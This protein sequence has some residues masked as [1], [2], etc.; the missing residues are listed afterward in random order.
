MKTT[1]LNSKY[2]E[3]KFHIQTTDGNIVYAN[4]LPLYFTTVAD[5]TITA[6]LDTE[7]IQLSFSFEISIN[8]KSTY[9]SQS[10]TQSAE[11]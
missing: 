9:L 11:N 4:P 2:T 10:H 6:S 3:N 5:V 8:R 1:F 7:S